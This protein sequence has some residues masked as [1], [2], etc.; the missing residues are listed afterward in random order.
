M[1]IDEAQAA[2]VR[3]IFTMLVEE[4]MAC[5]AVCRRLTERGTP[6]PKGG[7]IWHPS[8]LQRAS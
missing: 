4:R 6:A 3:E 1:E 2:V 5:R 8:V 7:R